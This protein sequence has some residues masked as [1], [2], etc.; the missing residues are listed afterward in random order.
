MIM[1]LDN[2]VLLYDGSCFSSTLRLGYHCIFEKDTLLF[3][4]E[5]YVLLVKVRL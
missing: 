3:L 1:D 2:K 4:R 5:I